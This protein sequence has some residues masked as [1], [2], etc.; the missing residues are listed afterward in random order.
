LEKS[1]TSPVRGSPKFSLAVKHFR[2]KNFV[3]KSPELTHH[4]K[5]SMSF[6]NKNN[7]IFFLTSVH[8]DPQSPSVLQSGFFAVSKINL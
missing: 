1:K 2:Q 8:P 7:Y 5:L 6:L 3:K 4:A